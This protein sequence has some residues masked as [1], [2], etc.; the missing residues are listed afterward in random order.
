MTNENDRVLEPFDLV[1]FGGTGD[2]T[3]RK[4]LPAMYFRHREAQL[5][6]QGRVICIARTDLTTEGFVERIS[7]KVPG[8]IDEREFDQES[9][10]SF[11]SRI[12]Y[13]SLDI[14]DQSRY[15]ALADLLNADPDRVRVFYLSTAPSLFVRICEGVAAAGLITRQSRVA[16]E[17]PLGR[18]AA[19]AIDIND[20]LAEY[21]T[22]QQIYRIDH[23]LGKETVQNLMALRF[24]NSLFEPLWRREL[25][26]DVQITIA[27]DLGVEGRAGF[28][29]Q[30]GALRDMV[31]NHILQL[32]VILAMEPPVSIDSDAIRDEKIKV[33]RSLKPIT[34]NDVDRNTVRGQYK[35]GVTDGERVPGYLESDDVPDDSHTE[36]FVAIKAEI[37]S[38]RWKGVPFFLRTGKRLQEKRTEIVINFKTVPHSI[39]DMPGQPNRLMI[40]LQPEESIKLAIFAKGRGDDMRLQAVNL[41]LDFNKIFK[42]RQM[43]AYERLLLDMIRGNQTLFNHR[44]E[45]T[46][47]WAWIDPIIAGWEKNESTPQQY[48]AGSWGPAASSALIARAGYSWF[49]EDN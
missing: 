9:W 37:D 2:L 25:I 1:I 34:G 16:L 13:V 33:L 15:G 23:Y 3:M 46:A 38:W 36:T 4:L 22:E 32:L 26:S 7:D 47:A 27:E 40:R 21:F 6:E 30:T 45:V 18:D 49:E 5:P 11:C 29:D 42:K 17:K 39:F 28:Y 14:N 10:R 35:S 48:P 12:E 19:S 44:D 24:G 20:R 8:F 31:Q 41:D 43:I